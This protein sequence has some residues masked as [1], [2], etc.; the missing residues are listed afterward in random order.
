[1]TFAGGQAL[2]DGLAGDAGV[3]C[4]HHGQH[5]DLVGVLD[6]Q[7]GPADDHEV[8]AQY[9]AYHNNVVAD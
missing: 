9:L 8:G 5:V 2:K 4:G 1:M 3:G 6:V 7:R